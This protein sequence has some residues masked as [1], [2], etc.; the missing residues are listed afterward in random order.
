M[1]AFGTQGKY[2]TWGV[3]EEILFTK[4]FKFAT[5]VDGKKFVIYTVE[6]RQKVRLH[7]KPNHQIS[8]AFLNQFIPVMA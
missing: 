7:R 5:S 4:E 1:F 2:G 3:G 6:G 8:R